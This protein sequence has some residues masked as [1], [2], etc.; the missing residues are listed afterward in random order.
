MRNSIQPCSRSDFNQILNEFEDFWDNDATRS[1]HH[2]M[3]IE[4]FSDTA[5]VVRQGGQVIAYLFGFLAQSTPSAYVHMVAVRRSHRRSKLA[6]RLYRHFVTFA[7]ERGCTSLKATA[8]PGNR[9]SIAFHTAMGMTAVGEPTETGLAVVS[10][11]GGP[12]ID[13]VVFKMAI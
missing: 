11:Y 12:G 2:P 9:R 1:R 3:F 5:W 13:R 7:R 6:E 8:D 4:E 10:D